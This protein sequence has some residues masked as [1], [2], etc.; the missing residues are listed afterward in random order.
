MDFSWPLVLAG[1]L[2]GAA[3]GL[4]GMGGGALMT[5]LLVMIFGVDPTAAVG[6]D[7]LAS[8]A[9]KPVGAAV[10]HRAGTVRWDF[11]RWLLPTAVPA[12]FAGAFAM[13]L[14]GR[15]D[16]LTSRLKYVIGGA[17]LLAVL[18]LAA[19]ALLDRRRAALPAAA[20]D[21]GTQ[22]VR[23]VPTL[24]I[25]LVGGLIVGLTSVGAGT[26]IIVLLML[27]HPRLQARELVG[28]DLVQAVP[29]VA[30]AAAGHLVAGDTSLS[31]A[32]VLL[33]GAIPGIYLGA[34]VSAKAPN[35]L[36]RGVLAILLVGSGLALWNVPTSVIVAASAGLAVLGV[37]TA[38]VR[39]GRRRADPVPV[40]TE[41]AEAASAAP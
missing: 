9:M 23:P 18:G 21:T 40:P 41:G 10:H 7:L 2:T 6:S 25:G 27:T 35:R 17:L 29:L 15:G 36:L 31:L 28:T 16:E 37:A 38:L 3:V 5:P 39:G 34:R 1:A 12:G 30:A 19:R 14:L 20:Q 11:V 32:G 33:L 13:H 4:T 22:R 8:V 26:L 24:L